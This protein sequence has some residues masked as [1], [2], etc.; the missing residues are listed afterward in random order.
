LKWRHVRTFQA[1]LGLFILVSAYIATSIFREYAISEYEDYRTSVLNL[2]VLL[3]TANNPN[4]WA[5]A[6]TADRRA[7]FFFFTYLLVGLFFLMNLVNTVNYSNYKAQVWI[8]GLQ[9]TWML[10]FLSFVLSILF[11]E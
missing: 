6:Y 4:V 8:I 11:R 2:F 3:T 9:V 10:I 7:F 1:L 5:D